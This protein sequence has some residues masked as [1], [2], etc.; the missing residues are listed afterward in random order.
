MEILSR[1]QILISD[2]EAHVN[3]QYSKFPIHSLRACSPLRNSSANPSRLVTTTTTTT[4]FNPNVQPRVSASPTRGTS[5]SSQD[6]IQ[7]AYQRRTSCSVGS[8]SGI[9]PPAACIQ[10]TSGGFSRTNVWDTIL[11]ASSRKLHFSVEAV[12]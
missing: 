2:M 1:F 12:M 11:S 3:H 5:H 6:P 7:P 8:G 9:P 10:R 4:H